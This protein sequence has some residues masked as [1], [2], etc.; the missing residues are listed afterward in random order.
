VYIFRTCSHFGRSA[1]PVTTRVLSHRREQLWLRAG[2]V[3]LAVGL[4]Q[5]APESAAPGSGVAGE[6]VAIAESTKTFFIGEYQVKGGRSLKPLEI[7]TAV[8]PFLGPDRTE[9]DVQAACAALEKA[10]REKGYIG[11]AVQYDAQIAKGG[12]ITL[13]VSEGTVARLRVK[14]ARYFSPAVI[15]AEVPSLAEG[16]AFN[17]NEV[18][19]DMDKLNQLPDR[20]VTV[21]QENL[22]PGAEPGTIEVDLQVK[23]KA[24]VHASLEVNNQNTANTKPLRTSLSVSDSN[25]A[26][27]GDGIGGTYQ[28]APQRRADSEVFTGYYLKR[29][30]GLTGTSF[31]IQG[32]KQNSNIS[33]LGGTTVA[34]PGQIVEARTNITLPAGKDWSTGKDWADFFHS[35]SFAIS[36][37]HYNQTIDTAG[38]SET[39][40]SGKIITPITYYP[41][42]IDYTATLRNLTG[43][44]STTDFSAGLNFNFRGLGSGPSVFEANRHNADGNY[45]YFRGE[46][47]HTQELWWNLQGFGKVSGQ[48]SNQPLVSS[49]QFS[50]GGLSTVRGYMEAQA[51]GDDGVCGTLELRSPSLFTVFKKP[52][53]VDQGA[54]PA[55]ETKTPAASEEETTKEWRF[56][57]FGDAGGLVLH[58]VLVDQKWRFGMVSVGA[59]TRISWNDRFSGSLDAGFPIYTLGHTK[60]QDWRLTFRAGLTY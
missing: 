24:P 41:L 34:G 49:E 18:Y 14:G 19:K 38:S 4:A 25:L 54:R 27:T 1:S 42:S 8:Y 23:D 29:F 40:G 6:P 44:D 55:S 17:V 9:A 7:E 3:F 16:R 36:Y 51:V 47:S 35:I 37:K 31:M 46:V 26:Q 28:V 15:K 39:S 2:L 33:T 59:G 30:A 48:L 43:K 12:V 20:R 58:D 11:A 50:G 13:R 53:K 21:P 56:H 45:I 57:I 32:T 10:Y 60:A 5:A 22:R 52:I